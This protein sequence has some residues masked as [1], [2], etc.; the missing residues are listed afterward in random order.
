MDITNLVTKDNEE[1]GVWT[2]AVLYGD[3]QD[4]DICILGSD[5]DAVKK[6]QRR[7]LKTLRDNKKGIES[8][9]DEALDALLEG[10]I[11]NIVVRI[12]GLRSHN[13]HEE[14][15]MLCGAE[16]KQDEASYRLLVEKIPAIKEFVLNFSNE[17]ANFL[18]SKKKR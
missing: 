13:K 8:F 14:P 10:D 18:S 16:L 11:D 7:Q 15:L 1:Q 4:F 9:S 12:A 6:F 3:K 5:S 17:R 2:Q